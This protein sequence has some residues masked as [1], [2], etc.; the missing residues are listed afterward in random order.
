MHQWSIKKLLFLCWIVFVLLFQI[1][2][3]NSA[4]AQSVE[5]NSIIPS[6]FKININ[7][8]N[9]NKITDNEIIRAIE[10]LLHKEIIKIDSDQIK[11][12]VDSDSNLL[13]M[14]NEEYNKIITDIKQDFIFW[15]SGSISD[16]DIVN[17]ITLLIKNRIVNNSNYTQTKLS[18]AIIDVLD[19]RDSN[20]LSSTKNPT[21]IRKC[22]L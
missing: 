13:F 3:F 20:Q 7:W 17:T 16:E 1:E 8:W 18:A 5:K 2:I 21:I 4:L 9:E 12:I 11:T 10:F 19:D 14:P 6:W 15:Q 22:R